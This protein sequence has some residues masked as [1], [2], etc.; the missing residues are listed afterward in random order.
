MT[1]FGTDVFYTFLISA[2]A[3]GQKFL[4]QAEI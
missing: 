1:L 3:F 2:T 4:P